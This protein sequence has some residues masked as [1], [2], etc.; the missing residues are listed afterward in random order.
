ML[1]QCERFGATDATVGDAG[2]VCAVVAPDAL[3]TVPLPVRVELAGTWSRGRTV[4]DRRAWSGDLAHDPR[5][6]PAA[7]GGRGAR[8]RR[9][10]VQ[11][12]V[13]RRGRWRLMGRVVVV[14]S[15]NIDLVT[16]VERHPRPGETLMG[17]GLQRL[18]GG[19]GANQAVAARLAGADVAM[20]GC[21]GDDDGGAAYV[22]RLTALG[23][24]C[25]GV[26]TRGGHAHRARAGHRGRGR[27]ERD[28]RRGRC[29]RRVG[30]RRPGGRASALEPGDVVLAQMEVPPAPSPR[31]GATRCGARARAVLNLAPY[32]GLPPDVVAAADP[33]VVN[34]HEALQ[35][36]DSGLVPAT[37]VVTFGGGRRVVGRRPLHRPAGAGGRRRGHH[38]RR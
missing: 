32:A 33:V 26:R 16:R 35:L 2:A 23:I 5:G 34:E 12:A 38:R 30:R 1:H 13:A 20:V 36:A 9:A 37:M 14:G 22:A 25:T 24:D 18:A 7:I 27:R 17:D 11:R 8:G 29:Q 21:V 6:A 3:T 28:R 31:G 19:K 15:L 10:P 4:V